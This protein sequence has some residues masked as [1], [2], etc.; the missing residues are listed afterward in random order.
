MNAAFSPYLLPLYL[1]HIYF[2][3]SW[4]DCSR[5]CGPGIKTRSRSCSEDDFCS[6]LSEEAAACNIESCSNND[7]DKV[8][9]GATYSVC[10]MWG[11]P[12]VKRFDGTFIDLLGAESADNYTLIESRYIS[13]SKIKTRYTVS[14]KTDSRFRATESEKY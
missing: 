11:D 2:S 5:D 1:I 3:F 8:I 6:G 4:S 7:N 14:V 10:K 12:H 9:N 13:D